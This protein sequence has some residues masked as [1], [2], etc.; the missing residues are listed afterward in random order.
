MKLDLR[1]LALFISNLLIQEGLRMLNFTLAPSGLYL[2]IPALFLGYSSSFVPFGIGFSSV[3]CIGLVLEAQHKGQALVPLIICFCCLHYLQNQDPVKS[4]KRLRLYL[5]AL[6]LVLACIW[7]ATTKPL[8]FS[9][10]NNPLLFL[11]SIGLSQGLLWALSLWYMDLQHRLSVA[12]K[13]R[14]KA[15]A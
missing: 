15:S 9:F 4:R 10:L 12:L 14:L 2:Y 13:G 8:V 6:N 7:L 5:Q 1:W 11:L 3:A